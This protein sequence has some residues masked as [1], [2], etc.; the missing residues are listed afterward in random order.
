MTNTPSVTWP[1]SQADRIAVLSNLFAR[2]M[3]RTEA[4]AELGITVHSVSGFCFRHGIAPSRAP[5]TEWARLATAEARLAR[6]LAMDQQGIDANLIAKELGVSRAT[7][8]D[9][10]RKT[11]TPLLNSGPRVRLV[12]AFAV[13][14]LPPAES[15]E[16]V[17]AGPV[18]ADG[19]EWPIEVDGRPAGKCGAPRARRSYCAHH[20]AL[21]YTPA[22]G[23]MPGA[24]REKPKRRRP[25]RAGEAMALTG[26]AARRVEVSVD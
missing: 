13:Y 25:I 9:L 23:G 7:I 11:K 17:H 14:P 22:T 2:G 15:W 10:T 1:D 18:L 8:N 5:N 21:A 24:V 4:A 6:V 3:G 26:V 16:A 12:P 20:H 19:C